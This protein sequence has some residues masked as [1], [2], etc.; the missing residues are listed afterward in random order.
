VIGQQ[1]Q[2]TPESWR[3][4]MLIGTA[5]AALGVAVLIGVPESPRWL[6][7]R[8]GGGGLPPAPLAEVL[9][10]PLLGRTVIGSL[11]GAVPM[12]GTWA[13]G[14]WLIP[15]ADAAGTDAATAQAVW[16]A[17]AVLGGA[18]GGWVADR[19]GRR[20]AYFLMSLATLVFNQ[21][22]Y[23]GLPPT[24]PAFLPAVFALGVVGT[25]FFGW[26]P[27]YL[28][29]LFPTRVRATGAGVAYNAG[30]VASAV[31]VLV[32]GGMMSLFDGDYAK[33]GSVTA[34]VYALGMAIVPFAPDTG[35]T[36]LG[37]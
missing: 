1:V 12:V 29:E 15:W 7:T 13:S 34:W 18:A 6:A 21:M 22:I 10:Q 35:R 23:R 28:P 20:S 14:K 26:L 31:G 17:G 8:A 33:V 30:R 36:D 25:L 24:H 19:V 37:D 16:A 27:L 11:L 2:V 32:A 9:R 5:P 3:W 4:A